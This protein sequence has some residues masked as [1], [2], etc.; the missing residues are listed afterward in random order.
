MNPNMDFIGTRFWKAK[1]LI[2]A[3]SDGTFSRG[4]GDD[5]HA[6]LKRAPCTRKA[7]CSYTTFMHGYA[8]YTALKSEGLCTINCLFPASPHIKKS[9]CKTPLILG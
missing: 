1:V 6:A 5:V 9:E 3:E 4:A 8:D 7:A 2:Q